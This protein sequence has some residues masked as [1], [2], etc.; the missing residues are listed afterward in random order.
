MM[1]PCCV[2]HTQLGTSDFSIVIEIEASCR[3]ESDSLP[4]HSAGLLVMNINAHFLCLQRASG[5]AGE[6]LE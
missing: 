3:T 6:A 2:I 5:G 4:Y 1:L